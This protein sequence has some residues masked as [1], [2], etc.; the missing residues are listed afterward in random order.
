MKQMNCRDGFTLIELMIVVAIIGILAAVAL[1]QF[2]NYQRKSKTAEAKMSLYAIAMGQIA[3]H[4][5]TELYVVCNPNPAGAP[6]TIKRTWDNANADFRM[7]GF[8][9]KDSNVFYTYASTSTD[10]LFDFTATA[11]GDLDGDGVLAV[12]QIQHNTPFSGP[13][14]VEAY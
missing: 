3:Y 6:T 11:T 14:P 8:Q 13:V 2:A 10:V 4:G 7:I 5:E 12:F 9:P 1:P